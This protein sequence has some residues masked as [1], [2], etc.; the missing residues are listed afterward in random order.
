MVC[1]LVWAYSPRPKSGGP[2][3]CPVG[4][5]V[6]ESVY[7]VVKKLFEHRVRRPRGFSRTMCVHVHNAPPP[8]VM[9]ARRG[10]GIVIVFIEGLTGIVRQ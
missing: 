3:A 8:F 9:V 6:F 2:V 1:D 10:G 4:A 7:E 5:E